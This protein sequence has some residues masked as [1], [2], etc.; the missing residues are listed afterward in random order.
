VV[1]G[2]TGPTGLTGPT[3]PTGAT[4]AVGATGPTGATGAASVVPGPTGP[5]GL[6]GL[7]GAVGPT[8]PAGAAG[9]TGLT[10]LTGAT[11]PQGNTSWTVAGADQYS[12]LSGNIGIGT[13]PSGGYK[14]EIAGKLKTSGVNE[15][16]DVRWKKDILTLDSSLL[17]IL[18]LRG[19]TYRWRVDEFKDKNF[20]TTPQIGLIAQE[21]EKIL[22]QLV[23]TDKEGFKAV[24]YS[25]IVAVLI[26]A[27]KEQQKIIDAQKVGMTKLTNDCDAMKA[28]ISAIQSLLQTLVPVEVSAK[29]KKK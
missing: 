2:P 27:I 4:G 7:T 5:T 23:E 10:G 9:P 8:G 22:P 15:S 16:S 19:V 28:D 12:S 26:E 24:E 13:T 21:V 1:P 20:E 29:E 11:G 18:A 25:K 17:K 14:L 3:G 6:T